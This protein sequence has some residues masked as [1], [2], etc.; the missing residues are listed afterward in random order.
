MI[1]R[2]CPQLFE[3]VQSKI[4]DVIKR[5]DAI[6][7]SNVPIGTLRIKHILGGLRGVPVLNSF[8]CEMSPEQGPLIRGK[9]INELLRLLPLQDGCLY[10]ESMFWYLLTGEIPTQQEI[11]SLINSLD[12]VSQ[13]P[14]QV[15]KTLDTLP[16]NFPA[17]S[18]LSIGIMAL[19]ENS[20]FASAYST[21]KRKDL[22]IP[23]FEDSLVILA[24][25]PV[26]AAYI[27]CKRSGIDINNTDFKDIGG[28]FLGLIGA[29]TPNNIG[30]LRLFLSLYCD[31]DS[32]SVGAHA[33]KAIGSPLSDPF[34]SIAGAI[35]GV[36]GHLHGKAVQDSLEWIIKANNFYLAQANR[37]INDN[38]SI[39]G[40]GHA[41]LGRRD[42]R[43]DIIHDYWKS[44][45]PKNPW[46]I[47]IEKAAEEVPKLLRGKLRDPQVN[48]DFI[49]GA[50]L[51]SFGVRDGE[52]GPVLF[53]VS[54]AMTCL[55]NYI[56]D[57]A[58]EMPIEYAMSFDIN[59][60]ETIAKS[61]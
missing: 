49:S 14:E 38:K 60:L 51:Y 13:L 36:S 5:V 46:L 1:S 30:F 16:Q 2:V 41:V 23:A 6:K 45:D 29:G 50:A 17:T 18:L 28:K 7:K 58:C 4:P 20:Q 59:G 43:Y 12:A 54:R 44:K 33:S 11:S 57:R 35:N 32:G 15:I 24:K 9:T 61:N 26:L 8:T 55:A 27:Y 34:K 47:N 42:P 3:K 22:W 40:F 39:P 37:D 19:Q 48:G 21:I 10:P 31:S 52:M 25:L 53:G 56:W